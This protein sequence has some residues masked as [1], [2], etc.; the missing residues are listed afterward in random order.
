MELH[1][2]AKTESQLFTEICLKLA[3]IVDKLIAIFPNLEALQPRD[4]GMQALCML[5]C[6]LTKAKLLVQ[7]CR[8]SSKL[9]LAITSGS[10]LVRFERVSDTLDQSLRQMERLAPQDLAKQ[11]LL[12]LL[13]LEQFT[14]RLDSLDQEAGCEIV[15]LFQREKKAYDSDVSLELELL[16]RATFKLGL[17]SAKALSAEKEALKQLHEKAH[18]Q[19]DKKKELIAAYLL[20]LLRMYMKTQKFGNL[21]EEGFV[22]DHTET[23]ELQACPSFPAERSSGASPSGRN[24]IAYGFNFNYLKAGEHQTEVVH[25]DTSSCSAEF[26]LPPEEFRCPISLQLM[27]E[28]VILASGQTYERV[29][30]ERWFEEGHD[31]CPKT[32]QKLAHL[33]VTPNY[34]V[35]GLIANWCEKH[36]IP[37][38]NPPSPPPSLVTDWRWGMFAD[39]GLLEGTVDYVKAESSVSK[40]I[41]SSCTG[42][43]NE[44]SILSIQDCWPVSLDE[45]ANDKCRDRCSH[46]EKREETG[47]LDE[48][49]HLKVLFKDLDSPSF[50]IQCRVAAK[51]CLI[52]K[53]NREARF[54]IGSSGGISALVEFLH[55]ASESGNMQAQ[56][57]AALALLNVAI[58]NQRNNAEIVARGAVPLLLKLLKSEISSSTEEAVIMLLLTVSGLHENRPSIGSSGAI[59]VLMDILVTGS[60]HIVKHA[61]MILSDLCLFP[62]NRCLTI[63]TGAVPK[64]VHLFTQSYGEFTEECTYLLYNLASLEEGRFAIADT[65]NC[66]SSLAEVLDT[67]SMREKEYV[68][69]TFL[70]LSL[71]NAE[72]T[73]CVLREGVIPSLVK[74]T[75]D[76]SPRAKDNAQKLLQHF[77]EQRQRD[78]NWQGSTQATGYS[79]NGHTTDIFGKTGTFCNLPDTHSRQSPKIFWGFK[80]LTLC[81]L[82]NFRKHGPT[83]ENV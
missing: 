7:Y 23:R 21:Q 32:R 65:E 40:E 44:F 69:E 82:L 15:A 4:S 36:G 16:G 66:I 18:N 62:E 52:A 81:S 78:C 73:Q 57:L 12:I 41:L 49:R 55:R 2:N 17:T 33:S 79:N 25:T 20:H 45:S 9:Y 67:G 5:H 51:I 80:L 47:S 13:E 77:R 24:A 76:G 37:T 63:Q 61:L 26:A 83:D 11:I 10:I 8:D 19:G 54:F 6:A 48:L 58:N 46:L 3:D 35:K 74:L 28:P 72:H 71:N 59:S 39:F 64:L 29:C 1:C 68:V 34:C 56:E 70:L 31:T 14:S 75:A 50:E 30:I 42:I 43:V 27:S 38:P 60:K 53:G 22:L